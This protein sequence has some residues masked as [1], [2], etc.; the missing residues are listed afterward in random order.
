MKNIKNLVLTGISVVSLFVGSCEKNNQKYK[1][2]ANFILKE[3]K[4]SNEFPLELKIDFSRDNKNYNCIFLPEFKQINIFINDKKNNESFYDRDLNG[5]DDY[6]GLSQK[7][8]LSQ[9]QEYEMLIDSIPKWY[10]EFKN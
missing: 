6:S 5:L 9:K 3:G 8:L 10:A 1:D 4:M 7:E 2:F